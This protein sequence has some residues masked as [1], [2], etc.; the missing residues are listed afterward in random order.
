MAN[1]KFVG[2]VVSLQLDFNDPLTELYKL[3]MRFS[4]IGIPDDKIENF[5]YTL[6]PPKSLTTMNL[7][8]MIANAEQL[9]NAAIKAKTGENADQ[10]DDANKIKDIMYNALFRE[11]LPMIN[12]NLVDEIY[13]DAVITLAEL[14]E[15]KKA[16][17]GDDDSSSNY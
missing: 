15:K 17:K 9:V 14:T 4:N 11:Y 3:I 1:S 16:N 6:N 2:R 13:N 7:A 12:W 5:I 10:T 8:D